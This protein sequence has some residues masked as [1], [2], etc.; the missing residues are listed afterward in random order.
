VADILTTI[1]VT[2][3][4]HL[5]IQAILATLGTHI[6]SKTFTLPI[7]LLQ[8]ELLHRQ[9]DI[10]EVLHLAIPLL[11]DIPQKV[12]IRQQQVVPLIIPRAANLIH[13]T[14]HTHL[15][16]V[17]TIP[18]RERVIL[19]IILA[20]H[21]DSQ[22][23]ILHNLDTQVVLLDTHPHRLDILDILDNHLLEVNIIHAVH[24]IVVTV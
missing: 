19:D 17:T 24:T 10:Q 6:T 5:I 12:V 18:S 15:K 22:L 3:T 13:H 2:H 16:L 11:V 21:L 1:K 9:A 8:R 4:I 7:G 20:I 23:L 14:T